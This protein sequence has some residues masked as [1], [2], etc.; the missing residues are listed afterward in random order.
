MHDILEIHHLKS[1]IEE[2]IKVKNLK[3]F[4]RRKYGEVSERGNKLILELI[5]HVAGVIP[6]IF[7]G[8]IEPSRKS[9]MKSMKSKVNSTTLMESSH[10]TLIKFLKE[11]CHPK[12]TLIIK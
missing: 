6:S 5:V 7:G 4:T 11:D 1:L 9:N 12:A 3:E 8:I 10:I 2:Q